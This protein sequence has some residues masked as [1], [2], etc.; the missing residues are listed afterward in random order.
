MTEKTLKKLNEGLTVG[1]YP[2]AELL[3]AR[4]GKIIFHECVGNFPDKKNHFFDLA[5]LTK[6]LCTAFLTM[7]FFQEHKIDLEDTVAKFFPTKIL[8]NTTIRELLNHTS[9]LVDW[10]PFYE[11]NKI[12]ILKSILQDPDCFKTPGKTI[13]SDLGFILL[14]AILEKIGGERLHLLFEKQ[15]AK[16]LGLQEKIFF[17]PL[18]QKNILDKKIFLPTDNCT[19]RKKIIQGEVMDL[20]AWAV[21]GVAGH[22]GLFASAKAIHKI[23]CEWGKAKSGQ[24]KIIAKNTFEKF[25]LPNLGRN[26]SERYFTLGFDTPTMDASQSGK[27]F[28]KNS[29]G[30]LGYSGTSFWWDLDKDFWIIFLTNRWCGPKNPDAFKKFRP[31][32]H[33][34]IIDELV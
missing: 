20:N 17:I 7:I 22:A 30:H 8:N 12:N 4:S 32:L 1:A 3:V 5:S 13:Y 34:A 25:C 27:K 28:S 6:P 24:S 18:D 23:L 21:G 9:G 10:K 26:P 15:I 2:S 29:I 14:G 19:F 11:Q 31:E 16:K 33:D